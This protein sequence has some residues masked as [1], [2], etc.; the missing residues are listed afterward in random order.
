MTCGHRAC[1]PGHTKHS[2]CQ[3]L[4]QLLPLCSCS[5]SPSL[6]LQQLTHLPHPQLRRLCAHPQHGHACGPKASPWDSPQR[7]CPSG[8]TRLTLKLEVTAPA[9]SARRQPGHPAV[10]AAVFPVSAPPQ[11]LSLP[12]T[13]CSPCRLCSS[14]L[15]TLQAGRTEQVQSTRVSRACQQS[16]C[17]RPERSFSSHKTD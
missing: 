11:G 4:R 13:T 16:Q 2:V 5:L 6:H 3:G 1:C 7:P 14:A 8:R 15:D 10:F 17:R 9:G 12:R